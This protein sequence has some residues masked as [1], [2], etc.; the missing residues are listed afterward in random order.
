MVHSHRISRKRFSL[1]VFSCF[2]LVFHFC[3]K[4]I[5]LQFSFLFFH[6]LSLAEKR[7]LVE[8]IVGR[9]PAYWVLQPNRIVRFLAKFIFISVSKLVIILFNF[10]VVTLIT[11]FFAPF[12]T[13]EFSVVLQHSISRRILFIEKTW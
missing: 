4:H 3:K 11:M 6:C 5:C 12:W 2:I 13:S 10:C 1:F 8:L 9:F 7:S